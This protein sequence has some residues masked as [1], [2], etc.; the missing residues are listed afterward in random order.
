MG[1]S[2]NFTKTSDL[3]VLGSGSVAVTGDGTQKTIVS[4]AY[5]ALTA[6]QRIF[7]IVEAIRTLGATTPNIVC[8]ALNQALGTATGSNH[9]IE[10]GINPSTTT[11]SCGSIMNIASSSPVATKDNNVGFDLTS[12]GTITVTTTPATGT[13]YAFNY[14]VYVKGSNVN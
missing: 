12:A 4:Q 8:G 14:I 10:L 11:Q 13:N 9:H 5:T 3:K 7:I 2:S 6:G 1:I